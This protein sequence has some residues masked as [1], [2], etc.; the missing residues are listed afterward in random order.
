MR[1]I[2]DALLIPVIFCVVV[3]PV[4]IGTFGNK[5]AIPVAVCFGIWLGLFYWN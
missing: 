5:Y 1:S 4:L 2:M 3:V